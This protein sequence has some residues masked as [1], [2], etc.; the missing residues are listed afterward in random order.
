VIDRGSGV[1]VVL[2]HGIQGRWEWMAPTVDALAERCRVVTFSL[3]D[4]PTSGFACDPDRGFENYLTQVDEAMD[5]AGLDSAVIVGVS[6]GGL[7]ATEF[8]A[9]RR[10]RVRG[11]VLVSALPYGWTPDRRARF[12]MRAPLLLSPLFC[13]GSPG[14]LMPEIRAAFPGIRECLRFGLSHLLRVLRAFLSPTRMA[15]RI[16]WLDGYPFSDPSSVSAPALIITGE[17]ALDKIVAPALTRQYLR[18]LP[19]AECV[20]LPGTG[21]IGVVTRPREFADFVCRFAEGICKDGRRRSA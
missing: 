20:T 7:I 19:Q 12:Y 14:R 13:V 11:L 2:I 16:Q 15:R 5:R 1:P 9:R 17:D 3:C 6:Y 21:H 4:E 10:E 18:H 8:A